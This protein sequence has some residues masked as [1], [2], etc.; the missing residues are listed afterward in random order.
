MNCKEIADNVN[1]ST[2]VLRI[3]KKQSFIKDMVI[4]LLITLLIIQSSY[5]IYD[6]YLDSQFEI[7]TTST[8]TEVIQDC[9]GCNSYIHGIGDIINGAESQ[10]NDKN[11]KIQGQ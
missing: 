3:V 6:R 11:N 5:T 1:I 8:T 4:I 10:N 9:D 2:E 7:E